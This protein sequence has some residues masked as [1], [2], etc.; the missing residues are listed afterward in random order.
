MRAVLKGQYRRRVQVRQHCGLDLQVAIHRE[1]GR[2]K[3]TEDLRTSSE[4]LNTQ[5]GRKQVILVFCVFKI[6]LFCIVVFNDL[7]IVCD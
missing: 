7:V 2:G 5:P 4:S 3:T 6:E 1:P